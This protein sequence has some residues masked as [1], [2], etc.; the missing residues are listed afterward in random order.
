MA[1]TD[2]L[3]NF[4]TDVADSIREKKGTTELIPASEFDT[5][6]DSISSGVDIN[7]YFVHQSNVLV[8]LARWIK[9]CPDLELGSTTT[10]NMFYNCSSLEVV[11]RINCPKASSVSRMFNNCPSLV[12]IEYVNMSEATNITDFIYQ[13]PEL[14]NVGNF[15]NLGLA[16][17][18]TQSTNYSYYTL[19]L[20]NCTKLTHDSLFNIING[21]YDISSVG[22]QPQQLILG[23]KNLAKLTSEEIAIATEKGWTVS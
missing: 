13:C 2:N 1:R 6:I 7:D 16:Y 21:L 12:T 10:A 14:S 17:L 4:L 19:T 22:V 3:S 11:D 20:A 15:Q 18:T 9:K 23:S 5:E 8:G